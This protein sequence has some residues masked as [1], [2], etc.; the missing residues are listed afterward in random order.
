MVRH[1]TRDGRPLVDTSMSLDAT[2]DVHRLLALTAESVDT[3]EPEKAHVFS[4]K[5]K[6]ETVNESV[7]RAKKWAFESHAIQQL[8]AT[9]LA[10][11]VYDTWHMRI[12]STNITYLRYGE[13]DFFKTHRD[14]SKVTVPGKLHGY[15]LIVGLHG[16]NKGGETTVYV[17][18]EHGSVEAGHKVTWSAS[19][20]N[21]LLFDAHLRHAA[22]AVRAGSKEVLVLDVWC[23]RDTYACVS[24][25]FQSRV[26]TACARFHHAP[27]PAQRPEL[28]A[29]L[30]DD[31]CPFSRE[32]VLELLDYEMGGLELR[33]TALPLSTVRECLLATC[34]AGAIVWSTDVTE[35]YALH[36]L[37]QQACSRAG[38]MK[39]VQLLYCK[40]TY[41]DD[42]DMSECECD[43]DPVDALLCAMYCGNSSRLLSIR[44]DWLDMLME[45]GVAVGHEEKPQSLRIVHLTPAQR[46]VV[47]KKYASPGS[48]MIADIHAKLFGQRLIH[49]HPRFEGD[50]DGEGKGTLCDAFATELL[51]RIMHESRSKANR[52]AVAAHYKWADR[53]LQMEES[54]CNDESGGVGGYYYL[55]YT[56]QNGYV[57]SAY[58]NCDGT[59]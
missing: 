18:D 42:G 41:M 10:K 2:D 28:Q 9:A 57:I 6:R 47:H 32:Q 8:L 39:E 14:F 7:R 13:G 17:D 40:M 38:Q 43:S 3:T 20:G 54:E 11:T 46:E 45:D 49:A 50:C 52:E 12:L 25:L 56:Q 5:T 53:R 36:G 24:D 15:T 1:V 33:H 55:P 35:A 19:I 23:I 37:F 21:M 30:N 29:F 27:A 48:D 59:Q 26:S 58:V 51:Q 4:L 22:S 44:A 34:N 16:A 31:N